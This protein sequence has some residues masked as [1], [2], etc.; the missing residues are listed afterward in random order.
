MYV[1]DLSDRFGKQSDAL[2]GGSQR[3]LD[4]KQ[5]TLIKRHIRR[6]NL[7]PGNLD[8][9]PVRFRHIGK[10][11]G[12][13]KA[14]AVVKVNAFGFALKF[15]AVK[16]TDAFANGHFYVSGDAFRRLNLDKLLCKSGVAVESNADL[17]N[18]PQV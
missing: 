9:P 2:V 13:V 17:Y 1:F 7:A 15:L 5:H 12:R 6:F 14:V 4:R 16:V 10:G 3:Q 11:L 18:Q 8:A